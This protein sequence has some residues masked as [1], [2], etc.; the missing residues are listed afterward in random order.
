MLLLLR[1]W[2]HFLLVERKD[3]GLVGDRI[4]NNRAAGCRSLERALSLQVLRLR[5]TGCRIVR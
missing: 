5:C 2:G 1:D 4:V 3:D